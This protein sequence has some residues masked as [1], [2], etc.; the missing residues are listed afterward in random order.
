MVSVLLYLTPPTTMVWVMVMF[1]VP[2]TVAGVVGMAISAVG[3][4]LALR[5]RP[6]VAARRE[7][8]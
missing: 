6:E 5:S 1:G 3:V 2:I 7:R 4:V 8:G